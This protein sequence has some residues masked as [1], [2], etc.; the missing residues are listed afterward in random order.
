MSIYF[1]RSMHLS[2]MDQRYKAFLNIY[3]TRYKA[4]RYIMQH[5]NLRQQS[6]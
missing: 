2:W 1:I 6:T 3:A 5:A 4:Y